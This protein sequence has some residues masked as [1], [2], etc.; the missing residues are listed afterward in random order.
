MSKVNSE[1]Q[2]RHRCQ[3]C[4]ETMLSLHAQTRRL[5]KGKVVANWN[6]AGIKY[7][8]KCKTLLF[9][10]RGYKASLFPDLDPTEI[11]L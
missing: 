5:I 4:G 11:K 8:P 10:E 6:K 7:C 3:K 9:F 1:L 2:K